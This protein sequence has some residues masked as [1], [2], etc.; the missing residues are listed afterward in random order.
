MKELKYEGQ[1]SARKLYNEL[2]DAGVP[3]E[4]IE[5]RAEGRQ[6][7]IVQVDENLAVGYEDPVLDDDNQLTYDDDGEI[8]TELVWRKP[9]GTPVTVPKRS[10]PAGARQGTH[11]QLGADTVK[12]KVPS[13]ISDATVQAVIDAHD[14]APPTPTPSLEDRI[15]AIEAQLAGP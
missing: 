8:I 3:A 14:P 6:Q 10:V 11:V 13:R 9:D 15:A 7:L 5:S 1:F 2:L 12:V 4:W